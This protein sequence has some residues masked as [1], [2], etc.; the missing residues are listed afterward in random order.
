MGQEEG[1]QDTHYVLYT[2]LSHFVLNCFVTV[3]FYLFI[4]TE[5]GGGKKE[6]ER[7]ID[8]QEKQ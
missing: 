2:L 8:V 5:R 3:R 1:G 6:R 4:F 7:N